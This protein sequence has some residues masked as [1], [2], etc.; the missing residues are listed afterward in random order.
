[1][2]IIETDYQN[3]TFMETEVQEEFRQANQ[4]LKKLKNIQAEMRMTMTL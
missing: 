3:I 1:M 4:I 2:N